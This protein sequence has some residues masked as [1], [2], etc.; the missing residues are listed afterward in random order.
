ML[1]SHKQLREGNLLSTVLTASG[2]I[3]LHVT[4]YKA[5]EHCGD[6][7]IYSSKT[8]GQKTTN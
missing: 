6:K 8:F 5:I 2:G 7:V 3:L 4:L 1:C